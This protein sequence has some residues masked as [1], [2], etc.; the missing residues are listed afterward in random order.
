MKRRLRS[1]F[2]PSNK[3]SKHARRQH[4]RIESLE[5]RVLMDAAFGTALSQ[6][7]LNPQPLPPKDLTVQAATIVS[8]NFDRVAL[9]P[10][11]L[12]PKVVPVALKTSVLPKFNYAALNPQPLPPRE[13]S[14]ATDAVFST[15]INWA[16]LNPQPLPPRFSSAALAAA[17]VRLWL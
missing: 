7:A 14:K 10:Q 6:A 5:R 11:P 8:S 2:F 4:L 9:N 15:K 3:Q 1:L 17:K 12:P 13:I 16:A